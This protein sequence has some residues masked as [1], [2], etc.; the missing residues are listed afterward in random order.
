MLSH[1]QKFHPPL[2]HDK[3]GAHTMGETNNGRKIFRVW[4]SQS[5]ICVSQLD[6]SGAEL[7]YIKGGLC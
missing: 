5:E 6:I 4:E 3:V 2:K 7:E 1:L